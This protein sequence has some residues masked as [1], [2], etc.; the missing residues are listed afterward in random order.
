M[1]RITPG[2]ALYHRANCGAGDDRGRLVAFATGTYGRADGVA[3]FVRQVGDRTGLCVISV[4]YENSKLVVA[5]CPSIPQGDTLPP[6]QD[7]ACLEKVLSAKATAIPATVAGPNGLTLAV[8]DSL[9]VEG[10]IL[11]AL[12]Q[13]GMRNYLTGDGRQV[14]WD[15]IVLTGHSQGAQLALYI[16]LARHAVAGVG[17]SGG[18]I[19]R[20]TGERHYPDFVYDRPKTDP[21]KIKAFHHRR[22]YDE[23]R[24]DAY[25]AMRVPAANVRTTD[26]QSP[27]C[28]KSPHVCVI[29]PS[30][31]EV[32]AFVADW[33][34]LVSR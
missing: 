10:S 6:L 26:H 1:L 8:P 19:S 31:D 32:A 14:R 33:V 3:H 4:P 11:N 7:P 30:D 24:R 21:T 15:R 5:Y 18:G 9:S 25:V 17:S 16:A 23:Y 13:L 12:R 34:W 2:G 22:D 29:L 27:A 28:T 20:T